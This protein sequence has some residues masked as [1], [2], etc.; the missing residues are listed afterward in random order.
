[1]ARATA[2]R[3]GNTARSRTRIG[4]LDGVATGACRGKAVQAIS[5]PSAPATPAAANALRQSHRKENLPN[6]NE[7]EAA[8]VKELVYKAAT[9]ARRG[10]STQS[11]SARNP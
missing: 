10:P 4:C 9:R 7:S 2:S 1:M 3:L 5:T 11:V 6:R 8:I